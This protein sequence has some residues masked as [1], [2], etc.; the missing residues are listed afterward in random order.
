VIVTVVPMVP[1]AGLKELMVGAAASAGDA[2][3]V[4]APAQITI[5]STAARNACQRMGPPSG[6][7]R[8]SGE[9]PGQPCLSVA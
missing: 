2:P 5:A 9:G 3:T 7:T 1:E 4:T 6:V 8:S